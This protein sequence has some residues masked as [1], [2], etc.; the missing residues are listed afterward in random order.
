VQDN[1]NELENLTK[2]RAPVINQA[3]LVCN[4][5]GEVATKGGEGADSLLL[6]PREVFG[7][8]KNGMPSIA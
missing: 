5:K 4:S 1:L 6:T 7:V 8:D 2:T 3:R